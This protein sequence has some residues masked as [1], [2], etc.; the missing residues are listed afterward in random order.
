MIRIKPGVQF[1]LSHQLTKIARVVGD[2]GEFFSQNRFPELMIL[3]SRPSS[4]RNM[5]GLMAS[6]V[7]NIG[8]ARMQAFVDQELHVRVSPGEI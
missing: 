8:K 1:S 4:P 7:C 5:M 6:L 2:E 3:E